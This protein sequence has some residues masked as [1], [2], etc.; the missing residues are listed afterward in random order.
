MIHPLA[1]QL[2]GGHVLGGPHHHADPGQSLAGLAR[3]ALDRSLGQPCD[4]EVHHLQESD[5]VHQEVLRLDVPMDDAF[6]MGHL[7]R[8]ADLLPDGEGRGYVEVPGVANQGPYRGAAHVFHRDEVDAVGFPEIV[9]PDHVPVGDA[10]SQPKLLLEAL[11]QCRVERAQLGPEHLDRDRLPDL[12][13]EGAVDHSHTTGPE[14]VEDV[15]PAGEPRADGDQAVA[16]S[17]RPCLVVLSR[18]GAGAQVFDQPVLLP[19]LLHHLVERGREL[20]DL[21]GAGDLDPTLV[22]TAGHHARRFHQ[23]LDR[24]GDPARHQHGERQRQQQA[25]GKG[26]AN[27]AAE[28]PVGR[29]LGVARVEPDVAADRHAVGGREPPGGAFVLHPVGDQPEPGRQAVRRRVGRQRADPVAHR[30]ARKGGD[31]D[32]GHAQCVAG[33]EDDLGIGVTSELFGERAVHPHRGHHDAQRRGDARTGDRNADGLVELVT[34]LTGLQ[35][36]PFGWLTLQG[37]ADQRSACEILV[38][39]V[40]VGG[41]GLEDP[42]LVGDEH[43]VG[44][45]L[46]PKL[47]GLVQQV[48]PVVRAERLADAR[49]VRRD[50]HQRFGDPDQ[51]AAPALDRVAD[52]GLRRSERARA[53]GVRCAVGTLLGDQQC[54]TQRRDDDECGA[55]KDPGAERHGQYRRPCCG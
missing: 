26:P 8:P 6:L 53:R 36:K 17:G 2:L 34:L 27:G 50:L 11:E 49:D 29:Q 43:P 32:M 44:A 35:P 51:R 46:A 48:G 37:S 7:E 20:P 15:V 28:L 18:P 10:P 14:H 22:L 25:A 42:V 12:A 55:E 5:R 19:Q 21:V 3:L 38:E 30:F 45:G 1:E 54:E 16:S 52:R 41:P 13:V 33:E 40:A 39:E 24:L 4:A 23:P 9:G 47:V 31:G